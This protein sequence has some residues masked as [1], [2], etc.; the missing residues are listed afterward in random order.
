MLNNDI[1]SDP[2]LENV[3]RK[4]KSQTTMGAEIKKVIGLILNLES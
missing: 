4:N 3:T 1:K 2:D